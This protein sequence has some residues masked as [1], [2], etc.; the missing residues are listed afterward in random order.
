MNDIMAVQDFEYLWDR[1][2]RTRSLSPDQLAQL[3]QAFEIERRPREEIRSLNDL[4]LTLETRLLLHPSES[5]K[6]NLR[7]FCIL[8]QHLQL[9]TEFESRWQVL[10]NDFEAFRIN[11]QE[12]DAAPFFEHNPYELSDEFIAELYKGLKKSSI[13][14]GPFLRQIGTVIILFDTRRLRLLNDFFFNLGY[15]LPREKRKQ[16]EIKESDLETICNATGQLFLA[17]GLAILAHNW[18]R[19]DLKYEPDCTLKASILRLLASNTFHEPLNR[20]KKT[21]S[22]LP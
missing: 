3:C 11:E 19:S 4:L 9:G 14:V 18:N 15:E 13:N 2:D 8:N 5:P 17:N 12:E 21:L 16:I 1:V 22:D 20:L 10:Q 7:S 6:T